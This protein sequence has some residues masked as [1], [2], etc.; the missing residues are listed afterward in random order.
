[1]S[2]LVKLSTIQ[3]GDSPTLSENFTLSLPDIPDG[4]LTLSRGIPGQLTQT[5][6][7]VEID[8]TI[9]FPQGVNP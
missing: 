5:I 1:M 3:I 2:A 7:V 8:G 6:M 9:T 4:T